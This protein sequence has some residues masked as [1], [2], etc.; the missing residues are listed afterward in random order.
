ML[1]INQLHQ[2]CGSCDKNLNAKVDN[3]FLWG[4]TILNWLDL[5]HLVQKVIHEKNFEKVIKVVIV[6][7]S[8][9][10]LRSSKKYQNRMNG[11]KQDK[12]EDTFIEV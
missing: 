1:S 7:T 6:M 8:R 5:I 11:K 4:T 3:N 10:Y 12:A 2:I 9:S